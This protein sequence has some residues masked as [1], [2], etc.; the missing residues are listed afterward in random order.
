MAT[1][2]IGGSEALMLSRQL[3]LD[4]HEVKFIVPCN[5]LQRDTLRVDLTKVKDDVGSHASKYEDSYFII[6]GSISL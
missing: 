2:S 5:N 6:C 4:F 3:H 1:S